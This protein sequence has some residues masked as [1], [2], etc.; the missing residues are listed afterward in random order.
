MEID[1]GPADEPEDEEDYTIAETNEGFTYILTELV[2]LNKR[3]SKLEK[4]VNG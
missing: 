1:Y 2:R 4:K 3:V